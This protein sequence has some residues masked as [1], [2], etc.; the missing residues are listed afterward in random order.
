VKLKPDFAEGY[1]ALGSVLRDESKLPQAEAAFR[2]TLRLKRDNADAYKEL[3]NVLLRQKNLSGA[4]EAYEQAMQ[5]KP[6]HVVAYFDLGLA[7]RNQGR[8]PNAVAA[9]RKLID[10]HPY[11]GEYA[12]YHKLAKPAR[13]RFKLPEAYIQLGL[14]SWKLQQLPDAI[15]AYRRALVLDPDNAEALCQLGSVL[16][17]PGQCVESRQ[18]LSRGHALGSVTPNWRH[19]SAQ[20][21]DEANRR[22]RDLETKLPKVLS[23]E[24]K[25]AGGGEDIAFAILCQDP[26]RQL[27][28][29][30]ADL[31]SAGLTAE[32]KYGADLGAK[33]RY[34]AA[35]AAA[36]AA[37]GQ[38][39]DAA[40]LEPS[41]RARLRAQAR[42]W[43]EDDLAAWRKML[44]SG[45]D[46]EELRR[47]LRHWQQDAALDGVR[48]A[49]ALAKLPATERRAWSKLW[50]DVEA[51][52]RQASRS[53][54]VSHTATLLKNGKVLVVGGSSREQQNPLATAD[55][56]DPASNTWTAAASM[57]TARVHHVAVLL[58][59][60]K[61][62]VAGGS[63]GNSQA[64]NALASAELYDPV[65]DTWSSAGSMT[66]AA[67]IARATLLK[68]GK[69]FVSLT[70]TIDRTQ[71][72]P[73]TPQLYDPASNT[74]SA[75]SPMTSARYQMH[76]ITLL[77]S[78][79]VLITGGRAR[80]KANPQPTPEIY[81]PATN[82]WSA[83]GALARHGHR[84]TDLKS[85]KVLVMGGV[86]A[87]DWTTL[88]SSA[89]LYDPVLNT[90]SPT[91]SMTTARARGC[92]AT[93]LESGKVFVT[94]QGAEVYD[95]DSNTWLRAPPMALER[96]AHTATLLETGKV[97]VVGGNDRKNGRPTSSAELFDPAT[98]TWQAAPAMD[99]PNPDA[100][101]LPGVKTPP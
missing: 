44:G 95:P 35:C 77:E 16:E 24:T 94:G 101:P 18:C 17:E 23:G 21:L 22:V 96:S 56:Y 81:D 69:V 88:L 75:T 39:K 90:W 65:S 34:D 43:L 73:P 57:A 42:A 25:A 79:K 6:E 53:A 100:A 14:I 27:Y 91:A 97:L 12:S 80:G 4:S 64:S 2:Q 60:G 59:D 58:P 50:N 10:G 45:P 15:A 85:G 76:E 98:N 74:W 26:S 52:S 8:L 49:E 20:W 33:T 11:R 84:A 28:K 83:A 19:P 55:L 70:R 99:A 93:R 89:E 3:G 40:G 67:E 5:R 1:F 32:P 47:M 66:N 63:D 13:D 87:A 41:E 7:L 51:L 62:L 61:V 38:G 78:G 29:A 48:N 92:T 37:S 54:R 46:K 82:T 36:R 31:F 86:V 30:A 9:F 68:S 71:H 72:D